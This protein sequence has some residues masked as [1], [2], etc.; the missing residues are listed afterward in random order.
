[1]YYIGVR[2]EITSKIGHNYTAKEIQ[3]NY[4]KKY[5]K[6]KT[7]LSNSFDNGRISVDKIDNMLIACGKKD[8]KIYTGLI[9][10]GVMC[11]ISKSLEEVERIIK[12]I[13]VLGNDRLIREKVELFSEGKSMLNNIK[14]LK[15]LKHAFDN[16]DELLPGFIKTAWF[17]APEAILK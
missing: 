2:A 14:E 1:M 10:F 8:E 7:K 13:N 4:N 3:K 17:Y 12:I 5:K 16:L 15:L 6:S 11:E 9:N